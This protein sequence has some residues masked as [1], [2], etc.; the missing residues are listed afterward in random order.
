MAAMQQPAPHSEF[1]LDRP[2]VTA[3][4]PLARLAQTGPWLRMVANPRSSRERCEQI[5]VAELPTIRALVSTLTRRHRLS[6]ADAE[7][8]LSEVQVR[9]ISNDYAVLRKFDSRCKL[10][11][12]LDTVIRR[13]FLD[14]RNAQWGRWRLSARSRRHGELAV[15]LERL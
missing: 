6:P 15:Q 7:D 5:F 14:Y 8:F 13:M 12:F 4:A 11:T 9:I 2:V 1:P 10:R 3:A